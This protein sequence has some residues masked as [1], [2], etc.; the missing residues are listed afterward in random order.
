MPD[1]PKLKTNAAAQYPAKKSV[2]YQNE[3]H[4]F[5]DGTEQRY[6]DS[7]GPLHHW[8]MQ[9]SQLDEGEIAAFEQFFASAQG[10]FASFVF[11]DPWDAA[12]YPNCSLAEDEMDWTAQAEMNGTT[13]LKVKENRQ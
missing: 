1:Y 6:R 5:I 9:F 4:R 10:A 3:I 12:A 2:R 8:D 7:A 13:R 11:T